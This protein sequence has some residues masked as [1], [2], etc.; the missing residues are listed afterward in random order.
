MKDFIK[1]L[2]SLIFGV[3]FWACNTVNTDSNLVIYQPQSEL[4]L[5]EMNNPEVDAVFK[6][7]FD[8]SKLDDSPENQM[9]K[10]G[11]DIIKFSPKYVGPESNLKLTGNHL[12][13][14]NCHLDAGTKP[15]S[16][17]YVGVTNRFPQYKGR[18]N[19]TISI[20]Q[21]INGCM[22]RSMNGKP[23]AENSK[24]MKA[25]VAYMTWLSRNTE[26]K[27][28]LKGKGFLKPTIPNRKIDYNHGRTVFEN[29][30]VSCHG[31]DGQGA[32]DESKGQYIYPPLWG[33]DSYN[34]GAGM[35]RVLTAMQFIKG[36]MPL[37]ATYD[38]PTLTDEE[39][40]D[41]AGYINSMTRPS[42]TNLSQDFPDL[43]QKPVSSPY[44]PYADK[45]SQL[46][47]QFGPFPEI[48]EY[49]QNTYG[50]KKTK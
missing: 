12:A 44:P 43:K 28:K 47:H 23:L 32:F 8:V 2:S 40:Y 3:I 49:Y 30:C 9:I 14:T 24:E 26:P 46:Q 50:L 31:I 35:G 27:N 29:Q 7:D 21:R 39:A 34:I 38:N 1:I 17:P 19:D 4:E 22:M 13:C 33:N 48:I 36:N 41:V 16:A 37:G 25:I 11:Y 18:S 5:A 20:E 15:Y 6:S 42:K 10:L 45:F